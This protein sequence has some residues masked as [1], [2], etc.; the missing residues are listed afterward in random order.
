MKRVEILLEIFLAERRPA[1][2]IYSR[3]LNIFFDRSIT[4]EKQF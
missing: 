3:N 4:V 1:F 2:Q